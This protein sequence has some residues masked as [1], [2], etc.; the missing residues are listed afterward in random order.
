MMMRRRALL[1]GSA[2]ALP[3][4]AQ[5][6][7][8]RIPEPGPAL[9]PPLPQVQDLRLANGLRLVLAQRRGWPLVSVN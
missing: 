3:A 4:W 2:L 5:Q 9:P 1:A 7:F 6:R 8:D